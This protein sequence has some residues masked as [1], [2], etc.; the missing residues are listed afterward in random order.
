VPQAFHSIYD[1][2][3]SH[4]A[5]ASGQGTSAVLV[6]LT[7]PR[8][9][10]PA[11]FTVNVEAL[12]NT[13]GN[14]LLGFYLPGDANGD[15]TVNAT[16]LQLVKS[17]KGVKASSSNY[18]FNADVNR[19]G[20]IG[21]IDTSFTQQNMGVSTNI[22]PVVQANVDTST[23]ITTSGTEV[24]TIPTASYTGTASPGATITYANT[25]DNNATTTATADSTGNYSITVPL[26]V[27]TNTFQVTSTDSFGQSITGT[28]T[29]V[30]F[31]GQ[32]AQN[33][34]SS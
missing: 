34:S 3:L 14:F 28:I 25:N 18:N 16:D 30:T 19:D 27:G 26:V 29:P 33:S 32:Q 20:R 2:H 11:T 21:P 7:L 31:L 9:G 5:V 22:S 13:S 4:E 23:V 15:G 1:P 24:S 8:Q 6:P 10:G 12:G 17:L